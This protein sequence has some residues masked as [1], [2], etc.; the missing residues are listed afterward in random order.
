MRMFKS[1][2]SRPS[3]RSC[4]QLMLRAPEEKRTP[5]LRR[6]YFYFLRE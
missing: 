5:A 3:P 1:W 4:T 6:G 2:Q